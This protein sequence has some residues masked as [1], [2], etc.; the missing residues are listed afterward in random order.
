MKN[1]LNSVEFQEL[2]LKRIGQYDD[3]DISELFETNRDDFL[4]NEQLDSFIVK[5][6]MLIERKINVGNA[7][8]QYPVAETFI[9][10]YSNKVRL[11]ARLTLYTILK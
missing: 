2:V 11:P 3:K 4:I 1:N 10:Q 7:Y 5:A 6:A 8:V 9:R